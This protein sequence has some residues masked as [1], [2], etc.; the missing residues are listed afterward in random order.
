MYKLKTGFIFRSVLAG[1]MAVLFMAPAVYAQ[2][3]TD[4]FE[5][6]EITVTAEKRETNLQKTPISIQT[7]SGTELTT[8]AKQ[9]IDDIMRGVVGVASQDSQVGVDFYMRGIGT[10]DTGPPT[11]GIRNAAVAVLIDGV[12]QNRGEVVRGGTLDMAQAEVMR[13]TQSTTLG[14]SSFAGAVSL[15][16]NKPV[17]DYE[18]SGSLGFGNYHLFTT[19]AVLNVPFAENQALRIAYGTEKRDGYISS[20]AGDSDQ[21]NGRIKYRWQPSEDLDIV[22]TWNHQAIGGNGVQQSVLTYYGQWEGYDSTKAGDYDMTAGYP[23]MLGHL[24]GEKYDERNDPWDDG[25]PANIWPNYPYRDT[26][27]NQYSANIDWDLGL[28]TLTILPSYQTATYKSQESPRG[29]GPELV[30][31]Y[32]F[33]DRKQETMQL[34]MQLASPAESSFKWL[35]GLYYYDTQLKGIQGTHE[36]GEVPV[37][38]WVMADANK[39]TTYAAYGNATYPI[40]DTL[41]L[42]G[43]VRYTHDEISQRESGRSN[44]TAIGPSTPYS[45]DASDGGSTNEGDWDAFTYRAG[46][47]Y[48]I[49]SQAM[50]YALF[51]TAYQPGG[52]ANGGQTEKQKLDQWTLGV[53]SRMLGN[54]LQ[55]NIEG[56]HNTYYNRPLQGNISYYTP[57]YSELSGYYTSCGPITG[58]MAPPGTPTYHYGDGFACYQLPQGDATLPKLYSYGA[59]LEINFLIAENDRL[60]VS[61]EYLHSV[62]GTPVFTTTLQTVEGWIPDA[63]LAEQVYNGLLAQA[64]SYDGLTLQNSPKWSANVSYSHIFDLPDGSTLTPKLNME[65][66]DTY[67]S[68][69]GGPGGETGVAQPGDSIQDAYQLYNF[70]LNWTASDD[71]FTVSGYIKNIEDKPILTNY[72]NEGVAYASLGPPRTFGVTLNVRF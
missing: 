57:G 11:A 10:P 49:S 37:W 66:K 59:D 48:D 4:T 68:Q 43:G 38:N 22:A 36:M 16:S 52:F 34:D 13:G 8:E 42:V 5:L 69:A 46:G 50:V 21:A 31:G 67:W 24:D 32:N 15:V 28:G 62:Q 6:E 18:G 51:A 65:Y 17:F 64:Q 44:G 23:P 39:Q 55:L 12:Y 54:R 29:M 20:G 3:D 72:T 1:F 9:R 25:Y 2:D 63:A 41:R 30:P 14:G 47:E 45:Y 26:Y 33:E 27:I 58:G 19:Q 56:Y 7:V 53:K 71:K 70:Y 40:L 61:T 35:G 60:D